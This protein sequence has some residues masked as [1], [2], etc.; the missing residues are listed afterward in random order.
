MQGN[1]GTLTDWLTTLLN[2]VV[3]SM[4]ACSKW[5]NSNP[6]QIELQMID[7][8]RDNP[9]HNFTFTPHRR[10]SRF[11]FKARSEDGAVKRTHVCEACGVPYQAASASAK[12]RCLPR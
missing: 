9:S 1:V 12:D 8:S 7:A 2:N 4:K 3:M 10:F 11:L 5:G 6:Q